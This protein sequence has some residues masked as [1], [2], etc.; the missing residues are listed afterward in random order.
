MKFRFISDPGHGWLEVP[1][2]MIEMLG[3]Q[4][5]IS[6]YSYQ[7]GVMAY[8]EEDCDATEFIRACRREGIPVDYQDV[9][10]ERTPIRRYQRFC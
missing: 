7:N 8:L 4:D 2:S 9:Y 6:H 1:I 10:E 3:I 5:R